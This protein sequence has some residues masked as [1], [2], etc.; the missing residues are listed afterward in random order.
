MTIT[1]GKHL[2]TREREKHLGKASD[3]DSLQIKIS[4][5]LTNVLVIQIVFNQS[6]NPKI[7]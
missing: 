7:Q 6:T 4:R 3:D 1:E 2:M 5:I